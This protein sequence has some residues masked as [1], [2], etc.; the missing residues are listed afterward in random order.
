MSQ[1]MWG[2]HNEDPSIDF[3]GGGFVAIGSHLPGDLSGLAANREAL[4]A[5]IAQELPDAKPRSVAGWAG[6]V[7]RFAHSMQ[8]GDLV[9][10]PVKSEST[11][12][13]GRVTG[14][15]TYLGGGV[16]KPHRR[17][18]V[19]LKT[20][21]PRT[22]FSQGALY[23]IGSFLA[24]FAVKTHC[25]E[26]FGAIDIDVENTPSAPVETTDA[27]DDAASKVDEP[28]AARIE[29][30]TQDFIVRTL[31]AELEGHEFEH[32]V[33]EVLRAMGYE[34]RVTQASG[35]GGV[36]VL[37]S[38]DRLGLEP[39]LIKIQC[40]RTTSTIGGPDVQALV[41]TLAH[42][43]NERALFVTLGGFSPAARQIAAHRHDV[44][45]IGAEELVS[46]LLEHYDA[47]PARYRRMLP[48]RQVYVV[49]QELE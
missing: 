12:A 43:G 32:L 21:I 27:L 9:V 17:S 29:Q 23:E 19:W 36:D 25:D 39:P 7:V 20:G 40:K 13:I 42:G 38:R 3:V 41:G 11:V 48:V 8:V 16:P 26:F 33:A 24:V 44:R 35:D 46:L 28:S 2:V 18:V 10:H 5:A 34:A 45:L 30:A 31:H 15:Y 37:A 14:Q 47:L 4:K 22:A 49:D 1:P 6:V